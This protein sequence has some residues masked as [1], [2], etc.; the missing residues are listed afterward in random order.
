MKEFTEAESYGA[1]RGKQNNLVPNIILMGT[2]FSYVFMRH[3]DIC[4][5]IVLF[6][7][8]SA[9][10]PLPI[11]LEISHILV[12]IEHFPLVFVWYNAT[13]GVH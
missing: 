3:Q 5:F 11:V 6:V 10:S 4:V 13:L 9:Q 7:N 8:F 1:F 2:P 12:L